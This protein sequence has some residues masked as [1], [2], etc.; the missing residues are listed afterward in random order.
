MLLVA[1][2]ALVGGHK[3]PASL[4]RPE[5]GGQLC[6]AYA[7]QLGQ[8]QM[9]LHLSC[10]AKKG[11]WDSSKLPAR[12]KT[13]FCLT[14]WL[15]SNDF[16]KSLRLGWPQEEKGRPQHKGVTCMMTL[17][18]LYTCSLLLTAAGELIPA[19]SWRWTI[20]GRAR[21]WLALDSAQS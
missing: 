4:L 8:E 19:L 14:G 13:Y 16:F 20:L 6:S 12:A 1:S 7:G 2:F 3:R 9:E 11:N 17:I 21:C 10:T 5:S 15:E 18:T